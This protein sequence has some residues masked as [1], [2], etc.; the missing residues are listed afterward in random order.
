M[1]GQRI[2]LTLRTIAPFVLGLILFGVVLWISG[3]QDVG[4]LLQVKVWHLLGILFATFAI[5]LISTWRWGL[6]I[7]EFEGREVFALSPFYRAF[8]VS[9]VVGL[10]IP[11]LASVTAIRSLFLRNLGKVRLSMGLYS[12]IIDRMFDVLVLGLTIGPAT[13]FY[14]GVLGRGLGLAMMLVITLAVAIVFELHYASAAH[15]LVRGFFGLS[16]L[17]VRL[18]LIGKRA[19]RV[20]SQYS[21]L[22]LV[23][24]NP[25]FRYVYRLSLLKYMLVIARYYLCALGTGLPVGPVEIALTTPIVQLGYLFS[26]APAGLGVLDAGWF[27]LLGL[28]GIQRSEIGLFL[29][30]QRVWQALS[31]IILATAPYLLALFHCSSKWSCRMFDGQDSDGFYSASDGYGFL[32]RLIDLSFAI[33]LAASVVLFLLQFLPYFDSMLEQIGL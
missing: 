18:P 16:D 20:Q 32:D 33:W 17:A 25:R 12:V 29:L 21:N 13:L 1:F 19:R 22:D 31:L 6:L 15:L 27:V 4:R 26:F 8:M 5:T 30:G 10:I 23:K 11:E 28:R 3:V 14:A 24:Q 9:R 7:N 2:K